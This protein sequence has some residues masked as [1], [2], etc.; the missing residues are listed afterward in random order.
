M[1]A[2]LIIFCFNVYI[3][4]LWLFP[5][6][7][8][9]Y[10]SVQ[11]Y[12]DEQKLKTNQL[13]FTHKKYN[14]LIIGSSGVGFLNADEFKSY[15]AYNYAGA[16]FGP[17]VYADYLKFAKEKCGQDIKTVFLGLEFIKTNKNLKRNL[18]VQEEYLEPISKPLYRMKNLL[19]I[20]TAKF[21]LKNIR[22]ERSNSLDWSYDRFNH[23]VNLQMDIKSLNQN[24]MEGRHSYQ[25]LYSKYEYDD[26]Y[27][28][29]LKNLKDENPDVNFVVFTVPN[30][31][32]MYSLLLENDLYDDYVHWL[33]DIVDVFGGVHN[34]LW[35][36][37]FM[38]DP[39]NYHD[40]N[41]FTC[42][43]GKQICDALVM[44]GSSNDMYLTKDNF[45][46]ENLK[47][48]F[49]HQPFKSY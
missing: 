31:K 6:T 4:P 49:L 13:Y 39:A 48:G 29:Y 28:S 19:S 16:G 22:M 34:F 38:N 17:D 7:S 44:G 24:I 32:P 11:Y 21:A 2:I 18:S 42:E 20:D 37:E 10:N 25:E 33:R 40:G 46:N 23:H 3:D 45:E 5:D 27:I 8:N 36:N 15:N 47:A 26:K 30:S 1:A 35:D 14:T 43:A 12:I 9:K 41:H